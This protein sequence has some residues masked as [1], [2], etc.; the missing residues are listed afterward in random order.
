MLRQIEASMSACA[1]EVSENER[2]IAGCTTPVWH[3]TM[4]HTATAMVSGSLGFSPYRSFA[5]KRTPSPLPEFRSPPKPVCRRRPLPG[6]PYDL[7]PVLYQC[8]S[9]GRAG[10][11]NR[12]RVDILQVIGRTHKQPPAHQRHQRHGNLR[13]HQSEPVVRAPSRKELEVE[14]MLSL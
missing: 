10:S 8:R 13:R 6:S 4:S 5:I 14:S 12:S 3:C 2:G 7:H 1:M 9:R 11:A